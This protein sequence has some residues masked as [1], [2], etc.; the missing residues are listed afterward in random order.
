MIGGGETVGQWHLTRNGKPYGPFDF[1]TLVEAVRRNRLSREDRV[2][3]PGWKRWYPAW[4]VPGLFAPPALEHDPEKKSHP[5][6]SALIAAGARSEDERL[7]LAATDATAVQNRAAEEGRASSSNRTP[8]QQ[9]ARR[10]YLARHWRGELS[11][12]VSYWLNGILAAIAI[13]SSA[14]LF[15]ALAEGAK[16]KAGAAMALGLTGFLIATSIVVAWQM[17]GIWRSATRHAAKGKIFWAGAAKVMVLLGVARSVFGLGGTFVPLIADHIQIAMGDEQIGENY[18]RLLRN[19]TELEFVG[20]LKT[21]TAKE[22]ERMLEAASQVRVVRLNSYGGR[23]AEADAMADAVRKRQLITYVS[24]HCESACTHIFLAGPQRWLGQK[25]KLGFHQPSIAGLDK[26]AIADV[27]KEEGRTLR[28]LGLPSEFVTKALATPSDQ[29]W[30]PTHEELLAARAISGISDGSRFAA[31]GLPRD[32]DYR[33]VRGTVPEGHAA[34]CGA[35]AR[36]AFG[37]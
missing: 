27:I 17:V 2:W 30:W 13:S 26:E 19:G 29:M 1:S 7:P 21:G 34:L 18:F 37:L 23:I 32:A 36:R 14:F 25:G 35:K 12:P 11:L 24:E 33:G 22:F 6:P 10:N 3:R 5:A 20:G 4:K 28:S 15:A 16:L 31:S 9:R 8:A